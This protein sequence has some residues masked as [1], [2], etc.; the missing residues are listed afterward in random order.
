M[1]VSVTPLSPWDQSRPDLTCGI[2]R[3]RE[4][5]PLGQHLLLCRPQT[6]GIT[7]RLGAIISQTVFAVEPILAGRSWFGLLSCTPVYTAIRMREV[8]YHYLS[9][10]CGYEPK[11]TPGSNGSPKT[12]YQSFP[13]LELTVR[14]VLSRRFTA[15]RIGLCSVWHSRLWRII[16][17][18]T[19]GVARRG[20]H[21]PL[22]RI[23]VRRH[24]SVRRGICR[25]AGP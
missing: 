2:V 1:K 12:F 13:S 5:Q 11:P 9:R 20:H 14:V 23:I 19:F 22:S 10:T 7:S 17:T 15:S 8:R 24:G 6:S 21:L 4:R 25:L 3:V 16:V 18:F